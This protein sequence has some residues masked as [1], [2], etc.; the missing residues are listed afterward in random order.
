MLLDTPILQVASKGPTSK[1]VKMEM[2][3]QAG[4]QDGS[5]GWIFPLWN[6][7]FGV[8]PIDLQ[9]LTFLCRWSKPPYLHYLWMLA[10]IL[11]FHQNQRPSNGDLSNLGFCHHAGD[12]SLSKWNITA[13]GQEMTESGSN[14]KSSIWHMEINLTHRFFGPQSLLERKTFHI[15]PKGHCWFVQPHVWASSVL[16]PEQQLPHQQTSWSRGTY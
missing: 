1:T 9:T 13:W 12:L 7:D 2:V 15:Q 3:H 6:H 8:V 10:G 14:P 16:P 4:W 5:L 11:G